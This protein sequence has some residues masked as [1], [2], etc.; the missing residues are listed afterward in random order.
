MNAGHRVLFGRLA[1]AAASVA[2][3]F[4]ATVVFE[5]ILLAAL[6]GP[7]ELLAPVGWGLFGPPLAYALLRPAIV[8]AL[9]AGLVAGVAYLDS[10]GWGQA[11]A[12]L[13]DNGKPGSPLTV[14]VDHLRQDGSR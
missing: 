5:F 12:G 14:S 1:R 11:G 3:A 10:K 2:A 6:L 8:V 4:T 7:R 9:P 13:V